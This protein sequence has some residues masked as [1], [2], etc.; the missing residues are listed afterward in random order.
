MRSQALNLKLVAVSI[1]MAFMLGCTPHKSAVE[2]EESPLQAKT[3]DA[4]NWSIDQATMAYLSGPSSPW[5]SLSILQ[6]GAEKAA[7][8]K[9]VVTPVHLKSEALAQSLQSQLEVDPLIAAKLAPLI[10]KSA[11]KYSVPSYL[12]AAVINKETEF[13]NKK[14]SSAGAI[15]LAQIMPNVWGKE[16]KGNLRKDAINLDCSAKILAHYYELTGDWE[17]ALAFYNV[18][19]GKYERSRKARTVGHRY[20]SGVMSDM[21]RIKQERE[22]VLAS[23]QQRL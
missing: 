20:A 14:R 2:S 4:F 6:R 3:D 15:G 7:R 9:P 8:S 13:D 11:A 12:I 5:S 19:P 23:I 17:Q 21:G 18:G 10:E 22:F 16:C 1:S